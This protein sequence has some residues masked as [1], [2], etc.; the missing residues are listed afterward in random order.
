MAELTSVTA[1]EVLSTKN[2]LKNYKN[3]VKINTQ[4]MSQFL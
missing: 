3:L 2:S 1:D 4:I